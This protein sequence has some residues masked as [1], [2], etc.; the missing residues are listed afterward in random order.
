MGYENFCFSIQT[1]FREVVT[2]AKSTV[3]IL[4]HLERVWKREWMTSVKAKI[5][6]SFFFLNK[7]KKATKVRTIPT[8]RRNKSRYWKRKRSSQQWNSRVYNRLL[9]FIRSQSRWVVAKSVDAT[10][11]IH[12]NRG[13][14][15]K[16]RKVLTGLNKHHS[17]VKQVNHSPPACVLLRILKPPSWVNPHTGSKVMRQIHLGSFIIQLAVFIKGRQTTLCHKMWNSKGNYD[18]ISLAES[19]FKS[20]C[21]LKKKSASPRIIHW[22]PPSF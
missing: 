13:Q 22:I 19:W 6:M 14:V 2:H 20:Q 16:D 5:V 15:L 11:V 12:T 9:T 7:K 10:Y 17:A 1:L 21:H 4:V 18:L 3:S 8:Q